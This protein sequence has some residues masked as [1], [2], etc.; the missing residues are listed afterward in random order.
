[1]TLLRW[2]A[3]L[4]KAHESMGPFFKRLS[5]IYLRWILQF[6]QKRGDFGKVGCSHWFADKK[7][8]RKSEVQAYVC[9]YKHIIYAAIGLTKFTKKIYQSHGNTI[10]DL[11]DISNKIRYLYNYESKIHLCIQ[12]FE[13]ILTAKYIII[14]CLLKH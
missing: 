7:I 4:L 3:S 14:Y 5:M 8:K 9:I 10:N 6:F 12:N 11:K 2:G 1:M 13:H